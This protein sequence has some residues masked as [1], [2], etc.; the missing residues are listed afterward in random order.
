MQLF[1]E[2]PENFGGQRP[3][4]IFHQMLKNRL[5]AMQRALPNLD[6]E[7]AKEALDHIDIFIARHTTRG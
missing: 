7:T 6:A 1:P 4:S 5:D 2:T 3:P